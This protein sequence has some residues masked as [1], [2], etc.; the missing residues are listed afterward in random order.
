MFHFRKVE[1]LSGAPL[2]DVQRVEARRL[3]VRGGVVRLGDE[4]L[5][6][7]AILHEY[8]LE[9]RPLAVLIVPVQSQGM[10]YKITGVRLVTGTLDTLPDLPNT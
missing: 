4:Q 6:A 8:R 5:T 9:A 1:V 3:E 10:T 7:Y 2:E